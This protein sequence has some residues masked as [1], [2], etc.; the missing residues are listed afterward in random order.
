MTLPH[1][2]VPFVGSSWWIPDEISNYREFEFKD[3][4]CKHPYAPTSWL[5]SLR[6]LVSRCRVAAGYSSAQVLNILNSHWQK[7]GISRTSNKLCI[8]LQLICVIDVI[9]DKPISSTLVDAAVLDLLFFHF[10]TLR[11]FFSISKAAHFTSISSGDRS[12][13]KR[14]VTKKPPEKH[15]D[16]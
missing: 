8:Y 9:A 4:R 16:P 2:T 1:S 5:E 10:Y 7:D 13:A 11:Y 14:W 15:G 12:E 6:H 3:G